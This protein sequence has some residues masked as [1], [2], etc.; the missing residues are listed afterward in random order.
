MEPKLGLA[1]TKVEEALA[2]QVG[3]AVFGEDAAHMLAR[4]IQIAG[5]ENGLTRQQ[6]DH[7]STVRRCIDCGGRDAHGSLH[8]Q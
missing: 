1:V 2:R 8:A 3:E 7:N 5:A 6:M 4:L